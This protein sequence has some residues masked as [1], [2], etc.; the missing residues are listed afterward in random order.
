MK[1]QAVVFTQ[2]RALTLQALELPALQAGQLEVAV[3]KPPRS[4]AI[5]PSF[6]YRRLAQGLERQFRLSDSGPC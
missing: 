3:E 2:P 4:G 6:R 1:A 5:D